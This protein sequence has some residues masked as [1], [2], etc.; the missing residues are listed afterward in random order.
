M[1]DVVDVSDVFFVE[2]KARRAATRMCVLKERNYVSERKACHSKRRVIPPR[3][4]EKEMCGE[5][6]PAKNAMATRIDEG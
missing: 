5:R 3:V 4:D 6:R 1:R 2:E